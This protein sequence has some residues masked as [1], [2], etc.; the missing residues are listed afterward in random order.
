MFWAN[1]VDDEGRE[2]NLSKKTYFSACMTAMALSERYELANVIHMETGEVIRIYHRGWVEYTS[3][4]EEDW[5]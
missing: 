1:V 4:C 5:N 3:P 2:H